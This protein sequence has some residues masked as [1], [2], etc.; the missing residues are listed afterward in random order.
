[1]TSTRSVRRV[2]RPF[3]NLQ[4]FKEA[5]VNVELGLNDEWFTPPSVFLDSEGWIKG[6]AIGL[7]VAIDPTVLASAALDLDIPLEAIVLNVSMSGRMLKETATLP[8]VPATDVTADAMEIPISRDEY[9][10]ILNDRF[11]GFEVSV[12]L[13][14]RMELPARAL[15][16]SACGTWLHQE[17]FHVLPNRLATSFRIRPLPLEKKRELGIPLKAAS[18]VEIM[19]SIATVERLDQACELWVD[20][21]LYQYLMEYSSTESARQ[22]FLSLATDLYVTVLTHA[23]NKARNEQFAMELLGHTEATDSD[24]DDSFGQESV[25]SQVLG[26]LAA[27]NQVDVSIITATWRDEPHKLRPFVEATFGELQGALDLLKREATE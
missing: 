25:L 27:K 18:Y 13:V 20:E 23:S 26:K 19:E 4:L 21:K 14:L 22:V 2:I 8:P 10:L 16:P 3:R 24:V 12:A 7:R 9:P 15:T 5:F 6:E 17:V 11:S 1:M